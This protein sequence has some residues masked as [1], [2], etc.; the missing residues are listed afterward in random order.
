MLK[1]IENINR[2]SGTIATFIDAILPTRRFFLL[3]LLAAIIVVLL[4]LGLLWSVNSLAE[5]GGLSFSIPITVE[6]W[7]VALVFLAVVRGK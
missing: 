5:L 7:F 2:V 1:F 6:S 4:P 3:C